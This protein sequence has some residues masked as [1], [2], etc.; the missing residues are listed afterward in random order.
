MGTGK[1]PHKNLTRTELELYY[2]WSG[3]EYELYYK[4]TGTELEQN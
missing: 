4:W 3:N 1:I 2:K